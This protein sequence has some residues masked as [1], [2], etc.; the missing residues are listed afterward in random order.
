V[1]AAVECEQRAVVR[2]VIV[3]DVSA[4]RVFG[5]RISSRG[6]RWL[7]ALVAAALPALVPQAALATAFGG[8]RQFPSPSDCIAPDVSATGC[9]TAG[10]GLAGAHGV[11][12]SHD[13]HNLYVAAR[14]SGAVAEFQRNGDGSLKQLPSPNNCITSSTTSPDPAC[15]TTGPGLTN[16]GGVVVSPDGR[17]VYTVAFYSSAIAEFQRNGD[18][19]LTQLS[20]NDACIKQSGGDTGCTTTGK[21]LLHA[22][23]LAISPDGNN[24][25]VTAFGDT[26]S[27]SGSAVAEFR[28]NADGT[29]TQLSTPHSCITDTSGADPDCTDKANSL[30]NPTGI[31][32]SPDGTSVYVD[33]YGASA[34]LAFK[35]NADGSLTQVASPGDCIA[36]ASTGSTC[37]RTGSG[38]RNPDLLAISPDQRNLYVAAYNVDGQTQSGVAELK[39]ENDGS[40]SQL[41]SPDNCITVR[42]PAVGDPG[43]GRTGAGLVNAHGV[44]V[45]PDGRNVYVASKGSS[46]VAE[47]QRNG[48]GSLTQ[49]SGSDN[50]IKNSGVDGGDSGCG[51]TGPGLF[52][53]AGLAVSPD[54]NGLNI[55]AG[56]FGDGSTGARAALAEFSRELP[57]ACSDADASVPNSGSV[58]VP[59]TC[60][61]P[62]G[63]TLSRSITSGPAHGTL[64]SVDRA[65]GTATYSPAPG[66]S[67]PDSFAFAASDGSLP[68]PPATV[69]LTVGAAPIGAAPI[70]TPAPAPRLTGLG[71]SP[72]SFRVSP[73]APFTSRRARYGATVTHRLSQAATTTFT[74]RQALP[75][76]RVPGRCARPTRGNRRAH[77]CTRYVTL[78]ASFTRAGAAGLNRFRFSGW[79]G[80]RRLSP[81]RYQLAATPR[82][83]T[84]DGPRVFTAFRVIK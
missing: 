1:V 79:L 20:G 36:E 18:G 55:Y 61:D 66:Y 21:G 38:L 12:I 71:V 62:N 2:S 10:V 25:Y 44:V 27:A 41:P 42:A 81:G 53:A 51:S 45:S 33:A 60:S 58:T 50:C 30:V 49:L 57:P 83:G 84:A 28:R 74:V 68:S 43:C 23:G 46:A 48:D 32:V 56:A 13:G 40:V 73:R 54:A 82:A 72:P 39:R 22:E 7:V 47:F 19:S 4:V 15:G 35:R 29:L 69:R 76:R 80:A 14:G 24:V 63:D 3:I 17:N 70:F 8:L 64:G 77:H 65:A 34:V 11:A 37:G 31:V 75:G 5:L 59:L 78:P 16:A 52:G 6:G 67:G 9:G 26:S